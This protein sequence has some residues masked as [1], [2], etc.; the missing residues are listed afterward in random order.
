M[1]VMVN[2]V[3]IESRDR[4][5]FALQRCRAAALGPQSATNGD[6]ALLFQLAAEMI[7]PRSEIAAANL[8][9][10]AEAFEKPPGV[11]QEALRRR[12]VV[13]LPRFRERLF[14]QLGIGA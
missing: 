10:A 6:E 11:A 7:S 14:K 5:A 9:R 2:A 3:S 13:S 1:R 4:E 8:V 12:L